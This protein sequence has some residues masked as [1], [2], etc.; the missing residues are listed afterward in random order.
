MQCSRSH[1]REIPAPGAFLA[2]TVGFDPSGL[3]RGTPR[4]SW[5][6]NGFD[7][8]ISTRF[9]NLIPDQQEHRER[10][11]SGSFLSS[12]KT[13]RDRRQTEIQVKSPDRIVSIQRDEKNQISRCA[14]RPHPI[15]RQHTCT[16][17][18][19][20]AE[21]IGGPI[22]RFEETSPTKRKKLRAKSM[23]HRRREGAKK[24]VRNHEIQSSRER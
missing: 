24:P 13:T 22:N 5:N 6:E 8:G 12:S 17:T 11:K 4:I 3:L 16:C 2:R 9:A 21:S 14:K 20:S 23:V 19:L 10:R 7:A 1:P 15:F 18:Q